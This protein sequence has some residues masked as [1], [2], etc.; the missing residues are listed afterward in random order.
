MSSADFLSNRLS[1][2]CFLFFFFLSYSIEKR[3]VWNNSRYGLHKYNNPSTSSPLCL[4]CLVGQNMLRAL[5]KGTFVAYWNS[6]GLV[7]QRNHTRC[8]WRYIL[9]CTIIL[10]NSGSPDQTAHAQSDQGLRCSHKHTRHICIVKWLVFKCL[11]DMQS[12]PSIQKYYFF[13]QS[14]FGYIFLMDDLTLSKIMWLLQNSVNAVS[15]GINNCKQFSSFRFGIDIGTCMPVHLIM[16]RVYLFI[17]MTVYNAHSFIW[18]YLIMGQTYSH[19]TYVR[20]YV[21]T[22]TTH[23][24][25]YIYTNTL[26]IHTKTHARTHTQTHTLTIPTYTETDIPYRPTDRH[27]DSL[28]AVNECP[29]SATMSA[30]SWEPVLSGNKINKLTVQKSLIRL[31]TPQADLGPHCPWKTFSHAYFYVC[32]LRRC[33]YSEEGKVTLHRRWG[34]IVQ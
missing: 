24:H 30:Q 8:S 31:R 20:T 10:A 29:R 9:Q 34:D 27:L 26:K 11:I 7:S 6:Q 12:L 23:A 17:Y 14:V 16:W 15:Q 19:S 18:L 13:P 3:I 25:T 4:F 2:K 21:N 33:R 32:E 28:T 1:V 22:Y 5:R